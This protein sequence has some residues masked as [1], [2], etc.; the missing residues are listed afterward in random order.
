MRPLD[1]R[2]RR[3]LFA[4]SAT[5]CAIPL[6]LVPLAAR[7]S[8]EVAS[9]RA[10][11]D[12]RFSAPALR[13]TWNRPPVNVSRDPFVPEVRV[14]AGAPAASGIVGVHVT[15][16]QPIGFAGPAAVVTAVVTGPSPRALVDDGAR[17]RVVGIGDVLGSKRIVS[18]DAVG[19]HLENGVLL[20]VLESAR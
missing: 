6:C 9:E 7:S 8:F 16:G 14:E 15:Q 11:F 19:V 10:A 17:V 18:I 5:L 12:A 20:P 1:D 3:Q 13:L 2:L 4:W